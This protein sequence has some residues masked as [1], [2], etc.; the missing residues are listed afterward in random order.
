MSD[1]LRLTRYWQ[2]VVFIGVARL[3]LVV[4]FQL[5]TRFVSMGVFRS[6]A[7]F[8]HLVFYGNVATPLYHRVSI[9]VYFRNRADARVILSNLS[10]LCKDRQGTA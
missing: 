10:M 5:M 3:H 1:S 8:S 2:V 7:R 6:W 4:V 9:R